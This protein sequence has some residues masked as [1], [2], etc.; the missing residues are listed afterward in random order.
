MVNYIFIK[1]SE[2]ELDQ[3][4]Q[5][6]QRFKS[7]KE[8]VVNT[9]KIIGGMVNEWADKLFHREKYEKLKELHEQLNDLSRNST[10]VVGKKLKKVKILKAEVKLQQEE[11][12]KAV[13]ELENRKSKAQEAQEILN[14]VA[15]DYSERLNELVKEIESV[16]RGLKSVLLRKEESNEVD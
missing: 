11:V 12:D 14:R 7:I 16:K 5:F 3:E 4:N 2:Y 6:V 13:L 9:L 8:Q 1:Y 10:N 15:Q